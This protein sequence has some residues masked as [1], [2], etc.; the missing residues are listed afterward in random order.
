M[1]WLNYQ[2]LRYFWLTA[3]EGNLTR[4]AQ[5]LRLSPSTVSAQIKT[6]EEMLGQELFERRG[7]SLVLTAHG[8]I[9]KQYADE[10][11][12]LGSEL[13]DA[14][15]SGTG[16][17]HAFRLRVG[18]SHNLPKLVAYRLLAPAIHLEGYPVHLVVTQDRA[19][20]LVAD[21][22]VHQLDL[23]LTD[24]PVGLAT[25]VHVEC[26]LLGECEVTLSAAPALHRRYR[27]GFPQ[28]LEGAPLLLPDPGSAMREL[29][30]GWFD[31]ERVRPR[32]VAEFDDSALLKAFGQE[33]AGIVPLPALVENEV[34]RQYGLEPLGRLSGVYERFFGLALPGK[35][36]NPAVRAVVESAR[37][38]LRTC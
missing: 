21:L 23:V 36:S 2:H 22:A 15:K 5:R 35:L 30:E 10:I 1:D 17:R 26:R 18:V 27:Q 20:R 28:S 7:R 33:G 4:A 38:V 29:L 11:F 16:P 3:R 12:G 34:A 8:E 14:V 32:V 25:D 9:V 19:D 37:V 31:R 6:L 24:T 13:M